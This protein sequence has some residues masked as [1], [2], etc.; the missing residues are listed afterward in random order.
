VFDEVLDLLQR[1]LRQIAKDFTFVVT[2]GSASILA[3]R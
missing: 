2:L 1:D 3:R